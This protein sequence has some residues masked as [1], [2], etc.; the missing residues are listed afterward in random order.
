MMKI[1][2]KA[3][4]LV[5]RQKLIH[6]PELPDINK[7]I[8]YVQHLRKDI[9]P[10][11]KPL[12]TEMA[13]VF[14]IEQTLLAAKRYEQHSTKT[15]IELDCQRILARHNVL[16]TTA[17]LEVLKVILLRGSQEF[18][19]ALIYSLLSKRRQISKAAVTTTLDLFKKRGIISKIPVPQNKKGRGR[20]E[21]KF[22]F[23]KSI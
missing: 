6:S 12:Q 15:E 10:V 19:V 8:E 7:Q 2:G 1:E 5:T 21:E 13:M 3:N 23:T 17:R 4:T 18:S 11:V 9:I 20:P 14:A 22:H 16:L